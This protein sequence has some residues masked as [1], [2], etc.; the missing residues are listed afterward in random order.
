MDLFY[1]NL[2]PLAARYLCQYPPPVF[3]DIEVLS[4]DDTEEKIYRTR[5]VSFL[6]DFNK[7]GHLL[8]P[9]VIIDD[10]ENACDVVVEWTMSIEMRRPS[11][12]STILS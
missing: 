3:T 9:H 5:T 12:L 11:I 10:V 1:R 7:N 6:E 4:N 8:F 2:I